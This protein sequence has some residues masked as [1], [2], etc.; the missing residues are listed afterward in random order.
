MI[1]G[2]NVGKMDTQ[3]VIEQPIITRSSSTGEE[4]SDW[5][6]FATV[7]AE[8]LRMPSSSE[9]IESDQQ[10]ARTT[11]RYKM[12]YLDGVTETMRINDGSILYISGIE[13]IDR[14]KF[15]IITAE[16]RDNAS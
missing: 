9:Q 8:K 7:W 5:S 3:V 15:L 1:R 12:R 4:L 11:V 16:K 10:V 6:T 14:M 13:R 2:G